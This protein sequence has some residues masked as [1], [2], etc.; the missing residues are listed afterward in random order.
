[1]KKMKFRVVL[2]KEEENADYIWCMDL[3]FVYGM[4]SGTY[5]M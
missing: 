1:M 2:E 4:Y 5:P 3:Y